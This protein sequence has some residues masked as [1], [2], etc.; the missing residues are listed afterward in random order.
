[1]VAVVWAAAGPATAPNAAATLRAMTLF[2]MKTPRLE[3]VVRTTLF[4]QR[5]A[6]LPRD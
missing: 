4:R 3:K 1:V 5:T 2:F 6:K